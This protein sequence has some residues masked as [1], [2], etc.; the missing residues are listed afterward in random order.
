MKV[1]PKASQE[2]TSLHSEIPVPKNLTWKTDCQA[3]IFG[4]FYKLSGDIIGGTS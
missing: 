2:K 1:V 4:F 3:T